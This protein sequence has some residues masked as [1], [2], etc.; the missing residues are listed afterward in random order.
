[1]DVVVGLS[2]VARSV[3]HFTCNLLFV[4]LYILCNILCTIQ[5]VYSSHE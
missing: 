1:M 3:D 5:A 2:S 4:I